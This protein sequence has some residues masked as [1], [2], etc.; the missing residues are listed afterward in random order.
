MKT[1]INWIIGLG[2]LLA[3]FLTG[4]KEPEVKKKSK[5][6]SSRQ[7][8]KILTFNI[9]EGGKSIIGIDF[10]SPLCG[11]PRYTDIAGVILESGA[12]IVG[13][14]EPPSKPD[15]LLPLL[16][17]R[18]PKWQVRGGSD[19]RIGINL[20]SRFPIEPDPVH[21]NDPT[22]H[23]VRISPARSVIVSTLHWWPFHGDG[24]FYIQKRIMDGD[25]P[26]DPKVL[27]KQVL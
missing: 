6:Q 16:Q 22:I 24:C 25:I 12:D 26:S 23:L 9:C 20:Y 5:M 18:D 14:N 21:P 4:A 10:G 7:V 2:I 8:L 1:K 15:L 11:G 13:V 17:A 19:G 27:E 3:L